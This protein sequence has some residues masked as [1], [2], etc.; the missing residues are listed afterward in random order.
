M[1]VV[2]FRKETTKTVDEF[3][4]SGQ[5]LEDYLGYVDTF[6]KAEYIPDEKV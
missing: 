4:K 1:D 2:N 6:L 5:S 3:K